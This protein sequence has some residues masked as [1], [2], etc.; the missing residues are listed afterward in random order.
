MS[1]VR[2][3]NMVSTKTMVAAKVDGIIARKKKPRPRLSLREGGAGAE[4]RVLATHRQREFGTRCSRRL[5]YFPTCGRGERVFHR[6]CSATLPRTSLG[7]KNSP[8]QCRV[9]PLSGIDIRAG[10]PKED[11]PTGEPSSFTLL[12][13]CAR[14]KRESMRCPL[15]CQVA[16]CRLSRILRLLRSILETMGWN[17]ALAHA[18]SAID[19]DRLGDATAPDQG[20]PPV[21][22]VYFFL[23]E[24]CFC[25]PLRTDERGSYGGWP[26]KQVSHVQA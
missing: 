13:V 7:Q 10:L 15:L 6:R 20:V 19:Q 5:S 26:F 8:S 21:G 22:G 14:G 4:G 25:W 23:D 16:L 9:H 12:A 11:D 1:G 24:A 3:S 18:A 17:F 2:R